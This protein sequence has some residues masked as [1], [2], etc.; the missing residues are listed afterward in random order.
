MGAEREGKRWE[1]SFRLANTVEVCKS[2]IICNTSENEKLLYCWGRRWRKKLQI[3]AIIKKL[4]ADGFFFRS[5]DLFYYLLSLILNTLLGSWK[6]ITRATT[7]IFFFLHNPH[8][9]SRGL[10]IQQEMSFVWKL[11]C[12]SF[13]IK[14]LNKTKNWFKI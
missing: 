10:E 14:Y 3:D 13:V 4:L 6:N 7:F 12:R 5:A 11:D 8:R 1:T 9:F 2:W